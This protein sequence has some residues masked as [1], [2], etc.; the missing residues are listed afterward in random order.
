MPKPQNFR[1]AMTCWE[2]GRAGSGFGAKVGGLGVVMEELPE[3]LIRVAAEQG[4]RL[5]IEVL[6]PCFGHYDRNRL[7]DLGLRI[8]VLQDG[9]RFEVSVYRRQLSDQLAMVYFWDDWQ[10][11]W[12]NARAIYPD[13]PEVCFLLFSMVSQ[14]MAGYISRQSFDTIH[15][16]DYHVALVPFY[17]GDEYLASVTHHLT[18][19]N[20][21]YQ[22]TYPVV[23][24]GYEML[25][26]INLP[27]ERLFHKYFDYFDNVNFLK[28]GM[29]KTHETGGK[30]TTVSGDLAG[31]WGYAAELRQ[32]AEELY[33]RAQELK[34]WAPV[35]DVF[36]SNRGVDA[37]RIVPILGITNG[38]AERNWPRHLPEL[39]AERLRELQAR[40]PG[41]LPLFRNPVVQEAMLAQDH[42]FEA[43]DL[44]AK[45]ELKRLLH[46][47][48]FGTE[49]YADP[50]LL[51]AVG[52]LVEQKNLGLVADLAERVL[53][54]DGGAKFVILASAPE[55]DA[56]GKRT[57]ARFRG[58]AWRYPERFYFSS[59]YNLPLS[60]LILAGGDFMLI[61]SRFEP[62]GLVDYEASLVGNVVI[63]H[64]TGGLA[65][66]AGCGYLYDWLDLADPIGEANAFF[67]QIAAAIR[68]YRLDPGRHRELALKAMAVDASWA[69]SAATY[70]AMYRYGVL[71]KDWFRKRTDLLVEVARFA[72]QLVKR[73]PEFP[74][75]FHPQWGDS[76][77]LWFREAIRAEPPATAA[78]SVKGSRTSP[79]QRSRSAANGSSAAAGR[80][81]TSAFPAAGPGRSSGRTGSRAGRSSGKLGK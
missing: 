63:A 55:G 65:K 22:G 49:P 42:S 46:L 15:G 35:K 34:P 43:P 25:N 68:I 52:R 48:T 33:R 73:D 24:R 18:I 7:E 62:C 59:E 37:F 72:S 9:H 57:E 26:R 5:E 2:P 44:A 51:T 6:S 8:P 14:A 78:G 10:L 23:G 67:E 50:I 53:A 21:S 40:Q 3:E 1:L 80:R 41:G 60:K 71:V 16:H 38:M 69:R 70:L 32:S 56:E 11:N 39:K 45:A 4:I 47:E 13:D 61:P 76:L 54:F 36:V 79:G 12:T 27:G 75:F 19:H 66:M 81:K 29:L 74:A 58:L 30:V 28:A 64:R 17:L 20:A 31:T 77:D